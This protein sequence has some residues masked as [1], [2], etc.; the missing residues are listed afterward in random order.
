MTFKKKLYENPVKCI[1]QK[2]KKQKQKNKK[3]KSILS[4]I[5]SAF[6]NICFVLN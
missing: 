5:F 3:K 1:L 4:L 2:E 6:K